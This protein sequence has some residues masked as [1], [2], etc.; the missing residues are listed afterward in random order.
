MKIQRIAKKKVG[1]Y[2][3]ELRYFSGDNSFVIFEKDEQKVYGDG[4]TS[5]NIGPFKTK[6]E[7]TEYFDRL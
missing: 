7:A 2:E 3:Y 6:R 5:K 1:D 4:A